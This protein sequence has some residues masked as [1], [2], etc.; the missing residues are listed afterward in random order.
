MNFSAWAIKKPIP[1][2]VIFI[3]A[4]LAGLLSFQKLLV[5]DFPDVELPI[6]IINTALPGA[7]P[8][9]LENDVARKLE[10][11]LA[12]LSDVRHIYSHMA[13][14]MVTTTVEFRLEKDIAVAMS[15]VRDGISQ[16]RADLPAE[17][18]DPVLSKFNFSAIPM[19]TFTVSSKQ[20]DEESL[21]WFVDN[22]VT[23]NLL[24]LKGVG[25]VARSGGLTREVLI[26]LDPQ[27]MAAL[28]VSAAEVSRQLQR[29]QQEAPGGKADI[30]GAV[31]AV[32][33]IATVAQAKELEQMELAMADGRKLR[34]GQVAKI[35]D[36]S[37]ERT[38]IALL[39][40]KQVVGFEIS[41]SKGASEVV[42]AKAV[43]AAL[44][45]LA[46][47][48]KS[49]TIQEVYNTSDVVQENYDGSMYLLYEGAALAVFVVWLFL[50]DWRATLVSA[51]ALP[52]SI[53]PTFAAMYWFDFSL[54]TVTLLSMA[55]VIGILVDDAIVEIENI[56]RH[57]RMGKTPYQAAMEAADE[58]GLAVIAT[59]FALIA[60]FLPTA[61]MSGVIG[62]FFKQFG[63]T[64]ALAVGASLVVA[65]LLTPM[66]A[67]YL[68]K[69]ISHV[70]EEGFIMRHYM[71]L[72]HWCLQNRFKTSVLSA[73]FF[74]GSLAL[75]PLL[76][77]GFLPQGDRAQTQVN[78][79]LPPGSTLL[80]SQ[81]LAEQARQLIL[82]DKD[83]AKVYT[84]I[85]ASE[86]RKASLNISLTD[87]T[88]RARKQ[89][90]IE[91]NLRLLLADLPAV[92]MTIGSGENGEL[93]ML[94][95]TS[96]DPLA[97]NEA[98]QAVQRDI[99]SIKGLGN[100]SSDASLLRPE[101]IITPDLAKAADLGVTAAAIGDT[102]RVATA[103][104]YDQSL[105]KL[106][107][108]ERQI[109]I[110]VR[111]P[112]AARQDL[113]LLARLQVPG[114]A[115]NVSL[116]TVASLR[117]DSGPSAIDRMDRH[118][119]VTLKV[120]LNG[121]QLGEVLDKINQL[122]SLKNLPASVKRAESGDAE[123]MQELFG[124]FA[125]AMGTGLLCVYLVL[126]LLFHSFLQPVTILAAL[127]LSI[128]GAFLALLATH[129]AFS[130]PSLIGLLML[131]GVAVKN[132]ILLV[133]YAIVARN[134]HGL[135]RYDALIDAC[136]K[137]A[138][139]IVMTSIAMAAGMLPIALGFG[140][141]PSFRSPMAIA[142][143]GGLIT[144][145][146]LSLL[147]IPVVFTYVDDVLQWT[148]KHMRKRALPAAIGKPTG[149]V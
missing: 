9:Q 37:A 45:E 51:A 131:M 112:L 139:P 49:V 77:Q 87:R 17:V 85:G 13:D 15:D 61:F 98:A 68:L 56:V 70:P 74:V 110:R 80:E 65:R 19:M 57:L 35:R 145:T 30:S 1:A 41:R 46:L 100:I 106:N 7:S 118:R 58:I 55:L 72:A 71:R 44:A 117:L 60:V 108:P 102:V 50:R 120:E 48:E 16:V 64:A 38:S 25:K 2:I 24:S 123:S 127:P 133:E 126:V 86:T 141:D 113:E 75:I 88:K 39:D 116:G 43:R 32:R 31:Q 29:V 89:A 119:N 3:L 40:G 107:L 84:V 23:K 130:M 21:S 142:V 140:A 67:A 42:V 96:D 79:E 104:D 78:L 69:P 10:N 136:H 59:T 33:T 47:Q 53:I 148:M 73:L 134:E 28:N 20:M 12:G 82:Q 83:V 101:V 125:I 137:R 105:A 97:L 92:R 62:R 147:V 76:P 14:G 115:G 129:N 99:R 26:E 4:T 22:Q 5:Q 122:P 90:E 63:W 109:P 124:G 135:S 143:I 149:E 27:Q 128:G 91:Q 132:S 93:L 81:N 144:S 18:R 52:L 138:Q 66:M 95:L 103:G 111:L 11:A 121:Q 94:M 34:L 114:K 36:G 54:N 6:V 146:V 8:A